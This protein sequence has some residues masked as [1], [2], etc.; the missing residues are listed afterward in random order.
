MSEL[1]TIQT[2]FVERTE[3]GFVKTSVDTSN[4]PVL[5]VPAD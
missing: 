2:I 1:P 3:N 5:I 4:G